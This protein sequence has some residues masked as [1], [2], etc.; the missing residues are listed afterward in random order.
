MLGFQ[1][2]KHQKAF[3]GRDPPGL[4]AVAERPDL[5][6]TMG[7]FRDNEV[8]GKG[9]SRKGKEAGERKGKKQRRERGGKRQE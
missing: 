5:V 6:T 3:G 9:E 4:A 8:M 1:P 2:E 7:L